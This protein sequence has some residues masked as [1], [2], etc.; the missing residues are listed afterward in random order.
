[1]PNYYFTVELANDAYETLLIPCRRTVQ[2]WVYKT[3]V[4]GCVTYTEVPKSVNIRQVTD[5]EEQL[6]VKLKGVEAVKSGIYVLGIETDIWNN[7]RSLK[8]VER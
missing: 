5:E 6:Q 1:M 2:G 8:L 7:L 4:D 3:L